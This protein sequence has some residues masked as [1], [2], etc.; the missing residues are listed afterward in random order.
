MK[1]IIITTLVL[2]ALAAFTQSC[3]KDTE[4]STPVNNTPT[5]NFNKTRVDGTATVKLGDLTQTYS[6]AIAFKD[7]TQIKK[8]VAFCE[9][10][11]MGLTLVFGSPAI[12][13]TNQTYKVTNNANAGLAA[14]EVYVSAYN[15]IAD[16]KEYLAKSG[17]VSY[18]INN[19]NIT[20]VGN[21][22][23]TGIEGST[24]TT[25]LSFNLQLK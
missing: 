11:T 10:D 25:P 23:V 8:F 9:N 17:T 20:I 1:K 2:S 22:V 3:K 14:D 15:Y 12:P 13:A 7:S 21:N 18:T 24:Q 5:N 19:G 16:D 6:D 4:S